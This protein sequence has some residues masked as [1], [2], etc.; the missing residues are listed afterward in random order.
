MKSFGLD[1]DTWDLFLDA[2]NNIGIVNNPYAVAQDS[3][4]AMR[5]YL[6][7]CVFDNTLGMPYDTEILGHA[8]PRQLLE[9]QFTEQALRAEDAVDAITSLTNSD[10]G[11]VSGETKIIDIEGNET[12]VTL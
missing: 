5:T 6:G 1:I 11:G 7:E 9:A 4:C 12:G 2:G 10:E 8:V 3:A